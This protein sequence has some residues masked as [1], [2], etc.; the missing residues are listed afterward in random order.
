MVVGSVA[1]TIGFGIVLRATAGLSQP[2]RRA[3]RRRGGDLRCLGG[4][5]HRRGA[6]GAS[7]DKVKERATIF[8]VIGVSTLSTL[9]MVLYP[10]IVGAL[11][12]G[13]EHAGIFLGGTIHDVA[14]VVGAGYSMSQGD[15]R[16]G[17]DRQAAARGDAAACHPV[18]TLSY[19][20][21]HLAGPAGAKKPP[22]LP[23][24][25]WPC[26]RRPSTAPA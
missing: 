24:F 12:L 4:D 20:K 3:H 9:A 6:A 14:Q 26:P 8:T 2:L 23:W 11:G 10:M 13:S 7:D 25:V 17:H 21:L 18:I 19:R 5:G 16:R 1:L 15:R 22:L